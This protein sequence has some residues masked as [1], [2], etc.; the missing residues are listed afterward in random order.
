MFCCSTYSMGE[1][2]D[3]A[4]TFA[5]LDRGAA[6]PGNIVPGSSSENDTFFDEPLVSAALDRRSLFGVLTQ[7]DITEV[8]S[9]SMVFYML[10]AIHSIAHE[11]IFVLSNTINLLSSSAISFDNFVSNV[12]FHFVSSSACYSST[13]HIFVLSHLN[14]GIEVCSCGFLCV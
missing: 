5:S 3:D 6:S 7:C 14:L 8:W 9:G 1:Q 4:S 13:P 12:L 11:A 2:C 10:Y